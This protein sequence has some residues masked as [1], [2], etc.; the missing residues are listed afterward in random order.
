MQ[1]H[2]V[3]LKLDTTPGPITPTLAAM[4]AGNLLAIEGKETSAGGADMKEV[5]TYSSSLHQL[6][7][8]GLH[9][10]SKATCSATAEYDLVSRNSVGQQCFY[11]VKLLCICVVFIKISVCV[12]TC[13]ILLVNNYCYYYEWVGTSAQMVVD[14]WPCIVLLTHV[15]V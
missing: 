7:L 11:L 13:G 15:A 10:W 1:W 4:L 6:Q 5:Y 3:S 9:Q 12:Q 14:H 8:L 2:S